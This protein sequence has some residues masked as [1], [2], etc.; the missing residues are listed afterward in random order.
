[1]ALAN[2]TIGKKL[3]L[4]IGALVL[5]SLALTATALISISSINERMRDIVD[6]TVRKQSLAHAISEDVAELSGITRGM[7]IR[8]MVKDD[9]AQQANIEKFSMLVQRIDANI[10]TFKGMKLVP[11]TRQQLEDMKQPLDTIR[12]AKD[13]ILG[14]FKTGDATGALNILDGQV[15]PAQKQLDASVADIL[16]V[17]DSFLASDTAAAVAAANASRWTMILLLL[18]TL[19]VA[20]IVAFVVRQINAV[21]GSSVRELAQTS[22]QIAAAASEVSSSSQSLAQGSSEQAATIEETSSV[23]VEINSMAQRNTENSKQTADIVTSSEAGFRK[24]NDSL[25]E[26]VVAMEG[27]STSSQ[28]ISK[29]IKVIDEIA[30]Q[31]NILALNAAV[32]AARAGEAG[33]GFAVV[34]DEV[35]SL[36]QRCAQAAKDT[37]DL[38]EDSIQKSDSGMAKVDQVAVAIGEITAQSAQIKTLVDEINLGSIEQSRGFDQIST[39]IGQMEQV[40][41]SSAAN[42]EETAAAAEELSAQAKAMD[43]IVSRLSSMVQ[44]DSHPH[45]SRALAPRVRAQAAATA[46]ARPSAGKSAPKLNPARTAVRTH[47]STTVTAKP[48]KVAA[49]AFPMEDDFK[50]F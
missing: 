34:A 50:E 30:F 23:S 1:M 41:Q 45:A 39:S 43:D 36:A 40:T 31:T 2:L 16:K 46:I 5:F 49:G 7:I 27:I 21:L 48:A 14:A 6:S 19:V 33:M 18:L 47:V 44:S 35:R 22:E 4:G 26:M 13:E 15:R 11:E 32:E 9:T 12:P 38:I 3:F 42:A 10:E 28:K 20:A 17:Q 8:G 25:G 29:I 37:T 24:A